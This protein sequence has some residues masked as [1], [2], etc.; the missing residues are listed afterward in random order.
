[1]QT[2]L[3][4]SAATSA[5]F[6]DRTVGT[7]CFCKSAATRPRV[8]ALHLGQ[9]A[10]EDF[11]F[12]KL[13]CGDP[14]PGFQRRH[15]EVERVDRLAELRSETIQ[16]AAHHT[17]TLIQLTSE[18]V[19]GGGVPGERLLPPGVRN[20]AQ[21]SDEGG[22]RREDHVAAEG[23]LEQLGVRAERGIE[24]RV[25]RNE[26]HDELGGRIERLPVGLRRQLV[27]VGTQLSGMPGQVPGA[28]GLVFGFGGVEV[29]S[30]GHLRVDHD[31][32]AAG[33][34]HQQVGPDSVLP[35]LRV[36]IAVLDHAGQFDHPLEL[37]LTPPPADLGCPEG[38]HE[39]LGAGRQQL[40]CPVHAFDLLTQARERVDP[41]PLDVLDLAGERSDRFAERPDQP[42]D[43]VADRPGLATG[44][45]FAHRCQRLPQLPLVLAECG[46]LGFGAGRAVTV[47][48]RAQQ[49]PENRTESESDEQSECRERCHVPHDAASVGHSPGTRSCRSRP[50]PFVDM[51]IL[52]TSDWHI[53]RTFHG[54]DLLADQTRALRAI[55][56][57]VADR[58]IDVVVVPGDVYDRSIPSSDAVAVCN[59]GFEAIRAAGAVIVATSGN[60]DSPVRLGAGA[61]FAAHGGLHLITRV[62]QIDDPVVLRDEHGPV[63]FYGIPYLEPEI[64]R[65][66][67]GVPEARS[68]QQILDAAMARVQADAAGRGGR[69]VVL[70]HAFVVGAEP[71]ESERSISVGG[72]ETVAAS[73]FDGAD[74][75][76]LG[77]LHSPQTVTDRVRYSGSPLPYSFGER[78]HRKAVFV[79]DL[80]ESGATSVERVELPVVRQLS[81]LEGALDELLTDTA[82]SGVEEHY[83][84][85]ALTDTVRPVDAMRRLQE[86]FPFAVHV[87]WR[88]P[89]GSAEGSYRDKV[90]GRT[91]RQ[92]ANAFLTDV[93]SEP[94]AREEGWIDQALRAADHRR[95]VGDEQYTGGPARSDVPA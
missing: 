63:A 2:L 93:R 78:T 62:S 60:H 94:S 95:G 69:T 74:Y 68:H 1:M 80:D 53:G 29:G 75:V 42:G 46:Q 24:K 22:G 54:V 87:E 23:V 59:A 41:V 28:F 17:E 9:V 89:E 82:H 50:L 64:T 90:R 86:R 79:V 71:S 73:S 19:D 8:D 3:D 38:G 44:R 57:L 52:H 81:K 34:I 20:R 32:L 37:D 47:A 5:C 4:S 67:L 7:L 16:M 92:I 27:D 65:T 84:S 66:E 48:G 14:D 88:R 18:T 91:D 30:E 55:A 83:I 61:A 11:E 33:E 85:A 36:E 15:G 72:V 40:R 39:L 25:A 10:V 12:V 6:V 35:D 51:R 70:A 21:Q 13:A 31:L 56:D 49:P 45:V 58:S 77:H 76:A 43:L 26:Q